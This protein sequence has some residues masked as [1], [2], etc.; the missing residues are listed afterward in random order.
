MESKLEKRTVQFNNSL[1]NYTLIRKNVKNINLR[2][3]PDGS[4]N[5]SAHFFV[6]NKQIDSFVQSK[7][8]FIQKNLNKIQNRPAVEN[9]KKQY[10][11]GESYLILGRSVRLKIVKSTENSAYSDG[12][13]LFANVKNPESFANR[14]KVVTSFL[15]N[16]CNK[17]F[18]EIISEQFPIFKKYGV[19]FPQL[20]IRSMKSRWGSCNYKKKIITLNKS[21]LSYP[22]SC[23]EYVSMHEYCHFLHHDH[24]KK[25]YMLLSVL[26]PNWKERKKLLEYGN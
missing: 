10:V 23:I 22:R 17:V 4:I 24:S 3:K 26:M 18:S 12:V 25:F 5:V 6:S 8:V 1:I 2:I 14:E 15:N 9:E 16:E 21:L 11:S 13:Y 19:P 7:G 20:K